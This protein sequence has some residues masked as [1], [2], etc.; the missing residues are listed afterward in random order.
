MKRF[1]DLTY[2]VAGC[3]LLALVL[4][5]PVSAH[6]HT[7]IDLRTI[8][9]FDAQGRISALRVLWTFDEFYTAFAIDGMDKDGDGKISH[10]EFLDAVTKNPAL[11][12]LFGQVVH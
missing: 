4:A 3:L 12:E 1:V 8:A 9:I 10:E 5:T 6:P 11:L 7:W 2:S